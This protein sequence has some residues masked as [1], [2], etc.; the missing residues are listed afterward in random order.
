MSLRV[1]HFASSDLDFQ[2]F[3]NL[4]VELPRRGYE[5][6]LASLDH[7]GRPHWR[8]EVPDVRWYSLRRPVRHQYPAAAVALARILRRHRIDVL[9]THQF[10]AGA[11]GI[12]A[13][14]L[15]GAK[16]VHMRHHLDEHLL[17]GTRAHVEV[18]RL[19]V[20]LSD[21]TVVPSQ[22]LHNYLV[23][24]EALDPGKIDVVYHGFDFEAMHAEPDEADR[25]RAGLGLDSRFV[26]G[27][28]SRF[29]PFKGHDV[30]LEAAARLRQ[31]IPGLCVLLVGGR[32]NRGYVE[33][34]IDRLGLRERVVFA[35]QR[36]DVAACM[37]AMDVLVHPSRSES[38]GK[39][40]LEG[41]AAETA[42]VA[43]RVGGIPE[44]VDEGETGLLVPADDPAAIERAVLRLH[45]E[46]ELRE[47]LA[48]EGRR[49]MVERFP[50]EA[51]L[52]HQIDVYERAA[53]GG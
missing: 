27:C 14:R 1:C 28:V 45:A 42:V 26:I 21:R 33:E 51:F 12:A 41:L 16:V 22:A 20:R 5:L 37:R 17:I 35:G 13:A 25:V 2:Y 11:V 53:R 49:R 3:R 18:D 24:E 6:T 48:R 44:I 10:D 15:A 36:S 50:L 7:V 34:A 23:T 38:F 30:L 29:I 39:V 8:T 32:G 31:R 9:Q 43:T 4:A 40:V 52:E 46:P 47:S 19:M